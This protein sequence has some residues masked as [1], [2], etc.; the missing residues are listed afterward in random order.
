MNWSIE[1]KLIAGLG[2]VLAIAASVGVVSYRTTTKLDETAE[3]V[4]HTHQV[5]S[6]LDSFRFQMTEAGAE[7]RNYLLTGDETYL[8]QYQTAVTAVAQNIER[9]R[10]LTRDNLAQQQRIDVIEPLV[11]S[12]LAVLEETTELRRNK[13]LLAAQA[14]VA[15]GKGVRIQVVETLAWM[16]FQIRTSRINKLIFSTSNEKWPFHRFLLKIR[17]RWI[18]RQTFTGKAFQSFPHDLNPYVKVS[19]S[20]TTSAK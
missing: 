17:T 8:E 13:G 3:W 16:A 11:K 4:E 20:R 2:L 6:E 18:F 12:R 19:D 5:L 7:E 10:K 1:R 15:A 14:L 9:L